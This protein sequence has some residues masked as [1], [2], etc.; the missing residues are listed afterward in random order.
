MSAYL[1]WAEYV[2]DVFQKRF[3]LDVVVTE[4]EGDAFTV[5][6]GSS[7]EE[8]EIVHQVT[9]VIRPT[10]DLFITISALQITQCLPCMNYWIA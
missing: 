6:A 7:V 4:Y 1:A 2:V 5:A 9:H 3:V 10:D 8:L